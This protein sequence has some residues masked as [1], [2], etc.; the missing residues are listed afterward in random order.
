MTNCYACNKA[1]EPVMEDQGD[2]AH[3][4]DS[5]LI[6]DFEGGYGMFTDPMG[7]PPAEYDKGILPAGKV[8]VCHD[9]AHEMCDALPW[10][11]K[12]IDPWASHSHSHGPDWKD[13]TGWDLPHNCP[14]CGTK[15]EWDHQLNYPA[16]PQNVYH[17]SKQEYDA[18]KTV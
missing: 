1:L 4:W 5:A 7:A 14:R 9:C 18:T 11:K 12:L 2:E 15:T 17:Y 13:H 6:I 8:V 10:V 3:Q 16:C